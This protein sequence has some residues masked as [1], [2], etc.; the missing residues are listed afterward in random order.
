MPRKGKTPHLTPSEMEIMA[1]LWQ[2]GPLTLAR[3]HQAFGRYG[4]PVGYP[5]MQTRLNRLTGKGWVRRTSE[6]PARYGAAVSVAEVSAGH[7]EQLPQPIRRSH[8]VPL[9]AHLISERPLSP[10]EIQDLKRL[11]EKAE[12]SSKHTNRGD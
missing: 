12:Q 8:V 4:R 9:V 5:T 6:R 10:E 1:M 3:A 2:E 11:L 7:L